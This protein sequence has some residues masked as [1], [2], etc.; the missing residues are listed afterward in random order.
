MTEDTAPRGKRFGYVAL[1]AALVL[2]IVGGGLAT[3]GI[4]KH[5]MRGFGMGHGWGGHHRMHGPADIERA[6]EHVKRIVGFASRRLDATEDQQKRLTAIAEAAT[7]E[8]LPLRERFQ[9]ARKRAHEILKQPTIDRAA[10][11][12]L[13]AEQVLLADEASRKLVQFVADAAEVLTLEQ[14]TKLAQRWDF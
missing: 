9:A 8:L 11:E 13:R 7:K 2:G 12:A 3:V 4:A 10:L 5:H 6:Q 1:V 14:R